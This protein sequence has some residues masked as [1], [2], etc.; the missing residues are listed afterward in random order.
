MSIPCAPLLIY[1]YVNCAAVL[2]NQHFMF[3]NEKFEIESKKQEYTLESFKNYVNLNSDFNDDNSHGLEKPKSIFW[4][5]S[6]TLANF[7]KILKIIR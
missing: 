6:D 3:S 2:K 1:S 4:L 7:T 5:L